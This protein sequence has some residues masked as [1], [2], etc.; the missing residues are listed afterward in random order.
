MATLMEP[1]LSQREKAVTAAVNHELEVWRVS[2][3]GSSF[4]ITVGRS[5]EEIRW[6]WQDRAASEVLCAGRCTSLSA[7]PSLDPN[8]DR[9]GTKRPSLREPVLL[10]RLMPFYVS[11]DVIPI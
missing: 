9:N 8:W 7:V 6:P 1:L 3:R 10:A 4:V 2:P 5:R 11:E